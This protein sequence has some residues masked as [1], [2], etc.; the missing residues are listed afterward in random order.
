MVDLTAAW[1]C[2]DC[3]ADRRGSLQRPVSAGVELATTG[4]RA[5]VGSSP[6]VAPP[7]QASE[8]L[9]ERTEK[10][11]RGGEEW[12]SKKIGHVGPVINVKVHLLA[13]LSTNRVYC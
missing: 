7:I 2:K 1:E 13:G 6:P 11:K 10:G 12:R 5:G 4:E 3:A 8:N 9:W